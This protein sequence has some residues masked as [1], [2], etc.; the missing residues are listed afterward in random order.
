MS[1][2]GQPRDDAVKLPLSNISSG[3]GMTY[4]IVS[5]TDR[6]K[7][8]LRDAQRLYLE[9]LNQAEQT[10]GFAV[11][12]RLE[13]I[14]DFGGITADDVE[15]FN[16][17]GEVIAFLRCIFMFEE[18]NDDEATDQTAAA[19]SAV[20]AHQLTSMMSCGTR[21]INTYASTHTEF[22]THGFN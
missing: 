19:A 12:E 9:V 20:S 2:W 14:V 15:V 6:F 1:W 3:M 16:K 22:V 4:H 18:I 5:R 10:I 21:L 17:Q 7:D 13:R 11:I 8:Y